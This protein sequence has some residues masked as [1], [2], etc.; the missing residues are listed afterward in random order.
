M[1]VPLIIAYNCNEAVH[2]IIG[3]NRVASAR[4]NQSLVA[5]ARVLHFR[6]TALAAELPPPPP[7]LQ[8]LISVGKVLTHNRCIKMEELKSL[9]RDENDGYVDM[10]FV[11]EQN[12]TTANLAA[13]CRKLRIPI[14]VADNPK[15]STFS[16]L[17]TYRSGPL[18]VSVSTNGNG[19]KLASKIRR[20]IESHLPSD[21]GPAVERFGTFRH[22][23]RVKEGVFEDDDAE[24]GKELNASEQTDQQEAHRQVRWLHQ[25]CEYFPLQRLCTLTVDDIENLLKTRS[26][27]IALESALTAS[28][29]PGSLVLV[30]SGPGSQDLLTHAASRAI[31]SA[32]LILTDKSV[33]S[34]ILS[35]IPRHTETFTA[36]KFPGNAENAQDELMK[37]GLDALRRGK[38]VVRLKQGDPYLFGR[39]AEEVQF[40]EGHGFPVHVIPGISS[41][42]AAPLCARIPVTHR[43]EANQVL[44]LTGTLQNGT[45]P[46]LP[47]YEEQRTTIF[48]MVLHRIDQVVKT[49]LADNWP[50]DLP[51][52]IIERASC[53]DQRS[54]YTTLQHL[55]LAAEA[56]GSRPPG[57]M[58]AGVAC[59][60]LEKLELGKR[61]IVKEEKP[62]WATH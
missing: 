43:G 6:A 37:R 60:V 47:H 26:D 40:F 22:N 11:C 53:K 5:N 55:A 31:E 58:I 13:A 32:D 15:L 57:L 52:V 21:L 61:W 30:G 46:K 36:R 56:V 24:N 9:G 51:C 1:A 33:P 7:D 2:V 18:Q 27:E 23:L 45:L 14:N 28:S 48:L 42:L 4:A 62:N 19:C 12:E 3:S 54:V 50:M 38:H 25:I 41:A 49:L 20:E 35:L 17:S 29:Q 44:I 8:D 10:V 16:L 59:Q 39:G 34:E